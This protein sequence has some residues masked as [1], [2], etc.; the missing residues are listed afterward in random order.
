MT[1]RTDKLMT[2]LGYISMFFSNFDF[3]LNEIN[4]SLINLDNNKLGNHISSKL[5]TN[6]RI[7]LYK[8][9]IEIIPFSKKIVDDAKL[10]IINFT[11]TKKN[12]N[13][14]I[15]GIWHTRWNDEIS[16]SDFYIGKLHSPNWDD[17]RE[18]KIEEL[19]GIREGLRDLL[20]KQIK[21]NVETL[22][23]YR[24]IVDSE[25]MQKENTF[26]TLKKI[27]ESRELDG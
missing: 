21:L 4:S 22:I 18:I 15:H 27:M 14:L 26:S 20:D 23:E 5:N 8:K 12:R 10:N 17:A 19:R 2:E 1:T 6:A 24:K 13:E 9:L 3:L 7:E 25:L 16:L 11:E